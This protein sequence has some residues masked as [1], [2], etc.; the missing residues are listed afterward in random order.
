MIT[1][2]LKWAGGKR[3]LVRRYSDIFNI[4]YERYVEPFVG[5]GAVFFHLEP[6]D[7]LLGDKN[8]E[9]MNFYSCVRDDAARILDLMRRHADNHSSYYYYATRS[10]SPNGRFERAARFLYLN[11]TCWNGLYRENKRGEFNVPIGTKTTVLFPDET[12]SEVAHLLS[13]AELSS[14]DFGGILE[15]VVD[16]DLVFVDPPYTVKHNNNGFVKYNEQIFSWSDQERLAKYAI[17]ASQRGANIIITN[18][19]HDSIIDLYKRDAHIYALQ[20]QSVLAG[21]SGARVVAEEALILLGPGFANFEST[22]NYEKYTTGTANSRQ[23][24]LFV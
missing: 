17:E 7:A 5:S 3:W 10:S 23:L 24:R 4:A 12:F 6:K 19:N 11:R 14:G 15:V 18:A 21:K 13:R 8:T 1:P 9:L 2:P 20:R 22:P 16:G